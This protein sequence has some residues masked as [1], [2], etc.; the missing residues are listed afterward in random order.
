MKALFEQYDMGK[1]VV[2]EVMGQ[3]AGSNAVSTLRSS[4][5]PVAEREGASVHSKREGRA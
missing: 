4:A 1:S 2:A 3:Q 5:K